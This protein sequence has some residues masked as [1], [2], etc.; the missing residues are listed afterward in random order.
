MKTDIEQVREALEE[1]IQRIKNG[2]WGK[3]GCIN[4]TRQALTLLDGKVLVDKGRL[5][6]YV[7]AY[8]QLYSGKP[9]KYTEVEDDM[10]YLQR[11]GVN[12]V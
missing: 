7:I 11:T 8:R 9:A 12:D 1:L 3:L 6:S 2:G 10:A 5:R 4:R